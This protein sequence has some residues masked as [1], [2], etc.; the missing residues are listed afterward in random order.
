[1]MV[2]AA[3]LGLRI[4]HMDVRTAFLHGEL[5]EKIYMEVP[6]GFNCEDS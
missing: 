5:D 6:E 2:K 1:M 4:E 3:M